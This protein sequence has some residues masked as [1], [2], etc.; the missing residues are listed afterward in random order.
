MRL[1]V[2]SQEKRALIL[3]G[4]GVQDGLYVRHVGCGQATVGGDPVGLAHD[5]DHHRGFSPAAH[6]LDAFQQV[7]VNLSDQRIG[8]TG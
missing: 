2:G 7:G 5:L 6:V 3:L 1:L 4:L 8:D